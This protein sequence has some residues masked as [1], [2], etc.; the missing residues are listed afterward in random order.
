MI[1]VCKKFL[2]HRQ[3]IKGT[4]TRHEYVTDD[5]MSHSTVQYSY[6]IFFPGLCRPTHSLTPSPLTWST[7]SSHGTNSSNLHSSMLCPRP[8]P[9]PRLLHAAAPGH[10]DAPCCRWTR[11]AAESVAGSHHP[12]HRD[13][14]LPPRPSSTALGLLE[15]VLHALPPPQPSP[16]T[17]F[18]WWCP[19]AG[20]GGA[21]GGC[22]RGGH[23]EGADS[24]A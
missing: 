5:Y 11:E 8:K 6:P 12:R 16:F 22:G 21:V 10:G 3:I 13:R 20:D 9:P 15:L 18:T 17:H 7:H 4:L 19:G 2:S 23:S 24:M 14:V 1:K